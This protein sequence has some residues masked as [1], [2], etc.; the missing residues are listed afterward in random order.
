MVA[1]FLLTCLLVFGSAHGFLPRSLGKIGAPILVVGAL[2]GFLIWRFGPDMPSDADAAMRSSS[3]S[4]STPNATSEASSSENAASAKATSPNLKKRAIPQQK[5]PS[6]NGVVVI[7]HFV[8]ATAEPAP[9]K[10]PAAP[11]DAL[12]PGAKPA[13][14]SSDSPV[15]SLYDSGA[16]RA[17]KQAT[18]AS[19]SSDSPV[20][21]P[22]DSGIKRAVKSVGRFLH[23]GGKKQTSPQ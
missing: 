4:D 21:S 10:G 3:A 7:R 1:V 22:Y 14:E 2:I 11:Q 6:V 23:I 13:S 18:P 17:I 9:L 16:K 19:E 15:S 12:E 5:Y 20:S 8:P